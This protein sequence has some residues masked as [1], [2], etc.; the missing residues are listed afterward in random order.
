MK[1]YRILHRTY[2]NFSAPVMLGAHELRLRP[3]ES[4]ELQIESALL[5]IE[6]EAALDW[7]RDAEDNSVAVATFTAPARQLAITSELVV[8]QHNI[9]PLD[10][11]L[12]DAAVNFPFQ[13]S[14]DE[15][16]VLAPYLGHPG[17]LPSCGRFAAWLADF[18][19]ASGGLETWQVLQQLN[20]SIGDSLSYRVRPEAGVQDPE[21]T[22][23][24]GS[25][26]CRDFAGLFMASARRMGLAARF[27][28]GYLRAAPS[29]ADLGATHAWAEVYLPG[30][31]WKGFDPTLGQLA[32]ADHFPVAVARSPELVPPV[33]GVFSGCADSALE[34]GV[35]VSELM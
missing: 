16:A 17:S 1:R 23:A 5:S 28:S 18:D 12:A 13:Y 21:S 31:G 11:R 27:V 22:L 2:Y 32:G 14:A 4:H 30:A 8:R 20:W 9:R 3:R 35:W 34:V 33:S 26:A 15:S 10:F 29:S 6:P 7:Y 25:G 19:C 24:K